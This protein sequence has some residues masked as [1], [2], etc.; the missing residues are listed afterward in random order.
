MRFPRKTR[1]RQPQDLSRQNEEC[2]NKARV[3]RSCQ[4]AGRVPWA[5]SWVRRGAGRLP[6]SC[7]SRIFRPTDAGTHCAH[8]RMPRRS[9]AARGVA[10]PAPPVAATA[11][12]LSPWR[13]LNWLHLRSPK[14]G[15]HGTYSRPGTRYR[16]RADHAGARSPGTRFI[17]P[18]AGVRWSLCGSVVVQAH[19]L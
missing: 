7:P 11:L 6:R 9:P 12:L 17:G 3:R 4:S 1:T 8:R 19:T 16:A 2:Q 14:G 5:G 13:R 10:A 18:V 15:A